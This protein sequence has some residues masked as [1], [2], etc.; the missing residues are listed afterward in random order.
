VSRAQ[1]LDGTGLED[2]DPQAAINLTALQLNT[3][4]TN[5]LEISKDSQLGLK[6]GSQISIAS[7]GIFGY[8]MMAS[9]TTGDAFKLLVRYNKVI[10]PSIDI[11][12]QWHDTALEL[13][14][15]AS[16]L[17]EVLERFY[18]G[19]LYAAIINSGSILLGSEATAAK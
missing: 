3:A 13:W 19:V 9:A 10:L 5:A 1:L 12:M 6:L 16:H 7:L 8:A 17:P 15:K 4:C 14:V 11:E 2:A 18:K